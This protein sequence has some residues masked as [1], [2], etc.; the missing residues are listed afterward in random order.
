MRETRVLTLLR[1]A[2]I[3]TATFRAFASTRARSHPLLPFTAFIPSFS[4]TRKSIDD[5][6]VNFGSTKGG[7]Q[8]TSTWIASTIHK[9][10]NQANPDI[11]QI[12]ALMEANVDKTRVF[13]NVY[14]DG[15]NHWTK[16]VPVLQLI[17][18]PS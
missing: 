1:C 15:L 11:R 9:M 17:F 5:A 14:S 10:H 12:A 7:K 8:T 18:S 13:L 2:T 6:T 4:A 16:Q 3:N